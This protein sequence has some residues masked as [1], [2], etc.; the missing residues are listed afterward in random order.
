MRT[1]AL[2][3]E[4]SFGFFE[5]YG[6][7]AR[8]GGVKPGRTRGEG[9]NFSRFCADF[10]YGQPLIQKPIDKTPVRSRDGHGSSVRLHFR[11]RI[12][13]FLKN[14]DSVCMVWCT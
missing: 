1:S 3:G 9:V 4:K 11:I 8:T 13:V 2:C 7:A 14:P 6:V 5:I 12:W 10:F